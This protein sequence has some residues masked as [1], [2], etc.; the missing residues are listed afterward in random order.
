MRR[1]IRERP[2]EITLLTIGPL[3]NVALLF[4]L[5]PEIPSLLKAWVSMAGVFFIDR[6]PEWN[7][8]CDPLATAIAFGHRP[9]SRIHVGLDVTLQC[10]LSAGDVRRRF[11][12]P[13][14]GAV[15]E[16]A[17][18]WFAKRSDIIFHDP[19]A[20]AVIFRPELCKLRRGVV[21]VDAGTGA[22][23]FAPPADGPD[24][25]ASTVDAT[26]FFDEYFSRF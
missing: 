12:G 6:E 13:L 8:R 15:L 11:T 16:I 2:G 25:V 17:A 1:V 22:T 14:L 3:T 4:A 7:A 26:L 9:S 24:E 10:K 18:P 23:R 5:D 19:L 20:A 21:G